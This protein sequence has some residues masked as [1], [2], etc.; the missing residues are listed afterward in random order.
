VY[1]EEDEVDGEG[2]NVRLFQFGGVAAGQ[3][4]E[5]FLLTVSDL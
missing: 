1:E 3:G 4:F 5:G 2:D